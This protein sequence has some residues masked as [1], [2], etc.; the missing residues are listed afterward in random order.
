MV[1]ND[2]PRFLELSDA[3]AIALLERN[4]VGRLA[5]TFHDRVDIEPISYVFD[6]RAVYGRTSAGHKLTT[7][8]HHPWVA[9][10]VDEVDGPYEWRSVVVHGT[11]YL[12][13]ATG[14]DRDREAYAH[15]MKVLRRFDASALTTEDAAPHRTIVFRLFADEITGRAATAMADQ[16]R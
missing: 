12:L 3:D 11:F 14:G 10:E 5:F 1:P 16:R 8:L 9:F 6:D 4:H 13:D 15:A 7:L 2:R